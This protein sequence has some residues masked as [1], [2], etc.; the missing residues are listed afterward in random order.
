MK[1]IRIPSVSASKRIR[2]YPTLFNICPIIIHFKQSG[3]GYH[4]ICSVSA[5]FTPLVSSLSSLFPTSQ[6]KLSAVPSVNIRGMC[7]NRLWS[8]PFLPWNAVHQNTATVSCSWFS[9]SSSLD[10]TTQLMVSILRVLVLSKYTRHTEFDT[11]WFA[12]YKGFLFSSS[13]NLSLFL[14]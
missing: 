5:P 11:C 3:Y 13:E 12:S 4:G 7:C 9:N 1:L 2:I 8:W 14:G 10:R 6:M